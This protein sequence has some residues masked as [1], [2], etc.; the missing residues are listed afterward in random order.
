[1]TWEPNRIILISRGRYDEATAGA[2]IYPGMLGKINASDAIIPHDTLGGDFESIMVLE[3]ALQGHAKE[4]K[5]ASG[6]VCPF[7]RCAKGDKMLGLLKAGQ[8]VANRARLMSAGD[9]TL[10]AAPAPALQT[11]LYEILAPSADVTN[12]TAETTFS[13]GS[14]TIPANFLAA[15]DNIR[16]RGKV[17][18]SAQNSTNTHRVKV[19]IGSTTL[20]DSGAVAL[21]AGQYVIWDITLTFRTVGAS[22]TFIATG[23]VESNPATTVTI[24]PV[25][26]AS[27]AVDTTATQAVIVTTTASAQSTGNIAAL[28]ELEETLDRAG[29]PNMF[30]YAQ[31]AKDNSGSTGT[32]PSSSMYIRVMVP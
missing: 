30:A 9:G 18:V 31:E 15:G 21:A 17:V 32:G 25:T 20:V 23:Y 1:M 5:I 19:K 8:N 24:T 3:D 11:T 27:T 28:Q 29:G 4:T 22:G 13:N 10:T 7:Q 2:D 14:Y 26:V 12:V 6:S 16:I